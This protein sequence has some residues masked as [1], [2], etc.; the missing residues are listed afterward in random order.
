MHLA[1]GSTVHMICFN[2]CRA[3]LRNT[4]LHTAACFVLPASDAPEM[5]NGFAM[6]PAVA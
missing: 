6:L 4:K 5:R 2:R 3:M 1:T